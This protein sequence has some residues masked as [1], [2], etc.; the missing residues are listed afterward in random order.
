[1]DK[2]LP[3]DCLH[4]PPNSQAQPL[5]SCDVSHPSYLSRV[6]SRW[7]PSTWPWATCPTVP[8][9]GT[10]TAL[11]SLWL[12]HIH[13]LEPP[14]GRSI[15]PQSQRARGW[16]FH[17]VKHPPQVVILRPPSSGV[18]GPERC[19]FLLKAEEG[20]LLLPV[21]SKKSLPLI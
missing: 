19:P 12:P 16:S 17:S 9:L 8:P 15:A 1:M 10:G 18:G 20:K 3:A 5:L 4:L 14:S 21:P 13:R 7:R 6:L 11:A 2:A